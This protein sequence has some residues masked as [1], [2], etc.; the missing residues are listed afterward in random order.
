MPKGRF[1][2]KAYGAAQGLANASIWAIHQD[3]EGFLW[4]GTE[5]GLYRYDGASFRA[6]RGA[7]GLPSEWI[8]TIYPAPSGRLWV[9]TL[10]GLARRQGSGFV[11]L[12]PQQGL[13]EAEVYALVED[14]RARL[15]VATHQGLF[16]GGEG[17]FE[18]APGW[19]AEAMAR[20]LWLDGERLLVAS[21]S[22]LSAVALDGTRVERLASLEERVDAV[23]R[24]GLG[25]LWLRGRNRLWMQ[26][27]DGAAFEDLS[28]RAGPPVAFDAQIFV[29]AGGV[30][31]MP[32][33]EGLLRIAGEDW[34][35]IGEAR[36]VPILW[37]NRL[38]VDA[39]GSLWVGGSGLHRI[40]GRGSWTQYTHK[41]G[42]PGG[43][44]RSLVRDRQG[45]MW[46]GT[47]RGLY[48]FSHAGWTLVEKTRGQVVL[49][50]AEA[51]D[52]A[53]WIGEGG[54][55]PLLHRWEVDADRWTDLPAPRS[56]ISGLHV[57]P[58]GVVW[59]AS[60]RDGLHRVERRDGEF[61]SE[62]V[63]LPRGSADERIQSIAAGAG[64]RLWVG[65]AHGLALLENGAW[66][67]FGKADG[68]EHDHVMAV[69]ERDGQL[70]VSYLEPY[71]LSRFA[72]KDGQLQPL[73]VWTTADGLASNQVHFLRE[74]CA[75][76]LWIGTSQGVHLL[77]EGS[78][79]HFS[80]AEGL[81]GD[82]C[83]GNTLLAE[84]NGDVWI[85]TSAGLGYFHSSAH[86]GPAAPPPVHLL[87][88]RTGE[89]T[90]HPPLPPALRLGSGQSTVEFRFSG[91]TFAEEAAVRH[92]VRLV[93]LEDAWRE[94]DVRQSRHA[95]LPPGRYRFEA[96]AG[97]RP[98]AWGPAAGF[99]L[100]VLP[101]WWQ[102]PAA[103]ALGLLALLALLGLIVR[104]RL[105]SL[106]RKNFGLQ[107]LVAAR[108]E[109][110]ALN[111]VLLKKTQETVVE[112]E[113]AT[114]AITAA[115]ARQA[116]G[117]TEQS[118]AIATTASSVAQINAIAE[119][120]SASAH[121][122][123]ESLQRTDE[124]S[125][126]GQGA[127]EQ[128][129]EGMGQLRERIGGI[130]ETIAELSG[131]VQR[132]GEIIGTVHEIAEQSNLLALNASIEAARAGEAGFG[133]AV[134]A[135]EMRGLAEQSRRATEQVTH[136]S[137]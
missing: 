136:P 107:E 85:G 126:H 129:I 61:H 102:H 108:T 83:A 115:S 51:P 8:R 1:A 137:C 4:V 63:A 41:D 87:S 70:W 130:A 18:P 93:G 26:P 27:A 91:L 12:G 48:R 57:E 114:A 55:A 89:R 88:V 49:A 38:F 2:F 117:A 39:E 73:G 36:G 104:T 13:P 97:L 7:D 86:R 95:A 45:R 43:V 132:A 23:A 56:T 110:L 17:R 32:S 58:S 59:V 14:P 111:A 53:L 34:Q 105:R 81:P 98:G 99:D 66:R 124:V 116:A 119:H 112:L 82:D 118:A 131:H 78:L 31:W 74:D 133:F 109:Q 37:V 25:R 101:A 122:V 100:V 67:R 21:G 6:F 121:E 65:G 5:G 79:A 44:V 92:Q 64:G 68:L 77:E 30:V 94:T 69:L 50:L 10:R 90:L 28:E 134:V 96:R 72:P 46:A 52:G 60:R 80:M 113:R 16:R 103:R 106:H 22:E 40:L 35:L 127:V 11:A 3:S 125:R 29:D 54:T 75:G 123:A 62:P 47:P 84:P 9:G 15:W 42:V 71:G 135:R 33:S 120:S 24:D 76:R 19:P 20:A 128:A